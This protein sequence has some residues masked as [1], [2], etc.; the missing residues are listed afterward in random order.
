MKHAMTKLLLAAALFVNAQG[1][2]SCEEFPS[3]LIKL[4]VERQPAAASISLRV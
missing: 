3:R 2:A 4:V 1:F